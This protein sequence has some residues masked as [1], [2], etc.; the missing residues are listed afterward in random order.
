MQGVGLAAL[1]IYAYFT[2]GE[3]QELH[4]QTLEAN[5]AWLAVKNVLPKTDH[6]L[7][8]DQPMY[9]SIPLENVGRQPATDVDL[10]LENDK[11]DFVSDIASLPKMV[12]DSCDEINSPI[13]FNAI[14]YPTSGSGESVPITVLSTSGKGSVVFDRDIQQTKKFY[15][16]RGCFSYVTFKARHHSWFCYLFAFS[17]SKTPNNF[18]SECPTGQGAD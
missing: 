7:I 17:N 12:N 8:P 1:I 4:Q 3:W 18:M 9:F 16:V 13:P 2:Y 15:R 11:V 6:S 14:V 5:R 10:R